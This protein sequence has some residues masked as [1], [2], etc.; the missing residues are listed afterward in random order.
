VG[1]LRVP[2]LNVFIGM[3]HQ[4]MTLRRND[5]LPW[6]CFFHFQTMPMISSL[7]SL[8]L[9]LLTSGPVSAADTWTAMVQFGWR[10]RWAQHCGSA[11]G[12]RNWHV[13]YS[14]LPSGQATRRM[15]RGDE[16]RS[17]RIE[18]VEVL[19]RNRLLIRERYGRGWG[20]FTGMEKNYVLQFTDDHRR[21]RSIHSEIGDGR[22]F[23]EHGRMVA[24][25]QESPWV[26]KCQAR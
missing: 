26:E 4:W 6:R 7:L 17:S 9:M 23:I 12:Y 5:E 22:E 1:L 14:G 18:R 15:M 19:D 11:A 20:E 8:A 24:T 2:D 16:T 13:E 21:Y 3:F 25:G 10:G